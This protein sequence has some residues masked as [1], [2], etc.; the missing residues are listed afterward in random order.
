MEPV[1]YKVSWKTLILPA[2]GLAAFFIYIYIFNVDIQEIIATVQRANPYF[3]LLATI[4]A[5]LDTLFYTLAWHALL[6]FLLV[7]IARVKLLLFVWVG[8]FIDTIVPA[9]SVSG[10]I[11]RIYLVNKEQNG[12]TGKATASIIAQRLIGT[13][14]NIVTLTV[15]AALL[16]V[17]NLF[18]GIMFDLILLLV[19]IGI[20]TFVSIIILS[21]RENWTLRIVD[22][23]IRFA[24]RVSRGRWKLLRLREEAL[25]ATRAFHSAMKDYAHAPKT[26]FVSVSFSVIAWILTLAVFYFT[27][28]SIGYLQVSWS[29]ILVVSAIFV[30]VKSVPVGIPFEVGLPE[31]TLT[32]LFIVLGIAPGISATVTILT[33]L[34]TLWLRFF[35]GF[36]AGQLIGL[37]AITTTKGG[38]ASLVEN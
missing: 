37:K 8:I 5:L 9:E 26:I 22:A 33:R 14:I 25:E 38:D 31:I 16:V 20:I 3:Y 21:A 36:A 13:G 12:A 2:I 29:A 15:G 28:A 18:Q 11:T 10:E 24:E 30:A 4:A 6:K 27:F 35:I 23:I 17:E 19:V 34:L 7:Q 1:K 32:T